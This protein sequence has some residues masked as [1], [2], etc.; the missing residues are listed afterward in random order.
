[1]Y[2][3]R[4]I[5]YN[6]V[7]VHSLSLLLLSDLTKIRPNFKACIS[8]NMETFR[9]KWNVGTMQNLSKPG[10]LRMVYMKKKYEKTTHHKY[11]ITDR[12]SVV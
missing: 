8:R 2:P 4:K 11:I 3:T 12:K 1:M 5:F 6:Q 10:D 7:K 9:C